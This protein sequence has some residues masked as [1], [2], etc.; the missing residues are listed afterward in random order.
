MVLIVENWIGKIVIH[1]Y[2]LQIAVFDKDEIDM[3]PVDNGWMMN[4]IEKLIQEKKFDL[5]F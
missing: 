1:N 2:N 4:L 5:H 3:L